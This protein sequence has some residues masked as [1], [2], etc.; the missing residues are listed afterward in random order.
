MTTIRYLRIGSV[1]TSTSLIIFRPACAPSC[2]FGSTFVSVPPCTVATGTNFRRA[3]R[4]LFCWSMSSKFPSCRSST[5]TSAVTPVQRPVLVR[6]LED[7]GRRQGDALDDLLDGEAKV[8]VLRHGPRKHETV[9]RLRRDRSHIC[10]NHVGGPTLGERGF[11][12]DP[13]MMGIDGLALRPDATV[14]ELQDLRQHFSRLATKEV[15]LVRRRDVEGMRED[16][17]LL[18]DRQ[19]FRLVRPMHHDR[20][21]RLIGSRARPFQHLHV[22]RQLFGVAVDANLD[23]ENPIAMLVDDPDG[24]LGID[25]PE[26]EVQLVAEVADRRDVQHRVDAQWRRVDDVFAKAEEVLAPPDPASM[27]VVTPAGNPT[28]SGSTAMGYA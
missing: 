8:E 27:A 18:Q 28:A 1:D 12:V 25:H 2:T 10:R 9:R 11:R 14:L 5:V 7:L 21:A 20:N 6:E 22:V 17:T 19:Q 4:L 23:R 15:G 26:A 16:V 13:E 3:V 24:R